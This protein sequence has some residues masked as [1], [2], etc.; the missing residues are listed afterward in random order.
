MELTPKMAMCEVDVKAHYCPYCRDYLHINYGDDRY[1][2]R[3]CGREFYI[4]RYPTN[5]EVLEDG[6]DD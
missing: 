1:L 4:L 6:N 3:N 2:C 5:G